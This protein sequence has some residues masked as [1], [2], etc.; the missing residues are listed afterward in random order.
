MVGK[1]GTTPFLSP[2]TPW[3][4]FVRVASQ[5]FL[6]HR[7]LLAIFACFTA[8]DGAEIPKKKKQKKKKVVGLK[9]KCPTN[10]L[11]N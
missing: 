10:E 4:S 7:E 9:K 5:V 6:F 3:L 1:A 2:D 11:T 8:L